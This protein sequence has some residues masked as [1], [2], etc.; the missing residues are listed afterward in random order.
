MQFYDMHSHILPEFDDGARSVE[1]SL[2]LIDCLKKQNVKNICLTP[3]FYT[4]EMSAEDFIEKRRI[5]YENFLPYKPDDVNI[6][7]G[8]EVFVTKFLFSNEDLSELTYGKSNYILTEFSYDSTFS[9]KTIQQFVMLKANYG[10][11]P[12]LPHFE[13]YETLV[14]DMSA[15]S[16]LRSLGVVIQTNACTYTQKTSFFKR[17]KL[18]KIISEGMVDILGTDAHSMTHNTPEAY[19]QAVK[20][21]SEKCG[22]ETVKRMMSKAEKIFNSAI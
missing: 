6:V 19:S 16:E 21:I 22:R 15:L 13:R 1:E 5:A 7:L 17:R 2:T 4:N 3:H 11:I 18:F 10:L 8:T 14:N 12:V 20:I 9:E